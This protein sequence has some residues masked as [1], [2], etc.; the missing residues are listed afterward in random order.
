[1][2]LE[3][4]IY[5]GIRRIVPKHFILSDGTILKHMVRDNNIFIGSFTV[6]QKLLESLIPDDLYITDYENTI[7]ENY[8]Q[9]VYVSAGQVFPSNAIFEKLP[10]GF[11]VATADWLGDGRLIDFDPIEWINEH[12][13][14]IK[15]LPN[16]RKV[17]VLKYSSGPL[18]PS[19]FPNNMKVTYIDDGID[20]LG[21]IY[22]NPDIAINC[23]IKHRYPPYNIT[24]LMEGTKIRGPFI[25]GT[26]VYNR[27]VEGICFMSGSWKSVDPET[28]I[29]SGFW[30][31]TLPF[32]LMKNEVTVSY[33]MYQMVCDH[34]R[35]YNINKILKING[36]DR[37]KLFKRLIFLNKDGYPQ[38]IRTI[39][40][41]RNGIPINYGS[42]REYIYQR[43]TDELDKKIFNPIIPGI[44]AV[45][46]EYK[47]P[48]KEVI[49]PKVFSSIFKI[50]DKIVLYRDPVSWKGAIQ[51]AKVG[52]Y[53]DSSVIALT[54][55]MAHAMQGDFDGDQYNIIR[56]DVFDKIFGINIVEKLSNTPKP[57]EYPVKK[58]NVGKSC[59]PDAMYQIA[60]AVEVGK[61]AT[62][63]MVHIR[64]NAIFRQ[65]TSDKGVEFI[66]HT[67]AQ[68]ALQSKNA[69]M[70]VD[71]RSYPFEVARNIGELLGIDS[72]DLIG[73]NPSL[74]IIR[75]RVRL[76]QYRPEKRSKYYS[77]LVKINEPFREF[78][79]AAVI[80]IA[81][82]KYNIPSNQLSSCRKIIYDVTKLIPENDSDKR[83]RLIINE[84]RK[85]RFHKFAPVIALMQM[86]KPKGFPYEYQIAMK[87]LDIYKEEEGIS[88]NF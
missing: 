66:Y 87:I 68:Q 75:K 6:S 1:M 62:G 77:D 85:R 84:V 10:N 28:A 39:E 19:V 74:A 4:I 50:G 79:P 65:L 34:L 81:L 46:I 17:K 3:R 60:K 18:C 12:Y 64:D 67:G 9:V 36:E 40:A 49:V 53:T 51:L 80:D 59:D 32:Y 78:S 15:D 47:S 27:N 43:L 37:S 55:R 88:F 56:K 33:T 45:G 52:G 30:I 38:R 41:I 23:K 70:N 35:P 20:H 63:L 8:I 7:R 26:V 21:T 14:D 54:P 58:D 82:S 5:R 13:T 25:K 83:A 29:K 44:R 73:K 42:I 16:D 76:G 11:Y 69:I 72:R 71:Y 2:K 61:S 22:V 48:K 31:E 57:T 24:H 86:M